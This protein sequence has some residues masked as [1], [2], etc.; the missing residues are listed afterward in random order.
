MEKP[1]M[2][3]NENSNPVE[4]EKVFENEKHYEEVD[5]VI[6][7]LIHQAKS[8]PLPRSTK[9]L[10]VFT[11]LALVFTGGILFGKQKATPS[12]GNGLSLTSFGGAGAGFGGAGGFGGGGGFGRRNNG[13]AGTTGGSFAIPSDAGAPVAPVISVTLPDDV[14]GTIISVS[15]KEIV[16]ESVSGEKLTFP[17]TDST[18]A[19][20]S[21]KVDITALKAGDI[22]TVKP[23]S[24]KSV[25]TITQ[26]K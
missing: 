12:T 24:D 8:R 15:S 5:N 25:K 19:R 3:N 7:D 22:V 10:A 13:G 18:K 21:S 6:V 17:I 9:A 4:M 1:Q 11:L 14:A 2:S 16:I 26:L 23:N 20:A